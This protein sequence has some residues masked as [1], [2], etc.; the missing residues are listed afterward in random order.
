MAISDL[1]AI[2]GTVLIVAG[3]ASIGVNTWLRTDGSEK[4]TRAGAFIIV[5]GAVLLGVSI[6]VP[7]AK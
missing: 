6:F 3:L 5:V 1:P 4:T 2:K 7:H